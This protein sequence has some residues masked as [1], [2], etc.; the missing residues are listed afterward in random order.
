MTPISP[1]PQTC[2]PIRLSP[3][4][5]RMERRGAGVRRLVDGPEARLFSLKL[6]S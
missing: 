4:H 6:E 2:A 3:T 5:A 1:T